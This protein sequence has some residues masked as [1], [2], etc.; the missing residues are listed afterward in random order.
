MVST[1]CG[2]GCFP[3][4]SSVPSKE[5]RRTLTDQNKIFEETLEFISKVP[6]FKPIPPENHVPLAKA[7]STRWFIDGENIIKQGDSGSEFFVIRKGKAA[8]LVDGHVVAI[9]GKGDFFGELAMLHGTPRSATVAATEGDV[10]CLAI[11]REEFNELD[12]RK[13]LNF[14]KRKAIVMDESPQTCKW[15]PPKTEEEKEFIKKSFM[16]DFFIGSHFKDMTDEQ[17]QE[18]CKAAYIEK[19]ERDTNIITQGDTKADFFYILQSGTADV[20]KDGQKVLSY[21]PGGSFG[22][23]ALV[24]QAPRAATVRITS[25]SQVW[26]IPRSAMRKALQQHVKAKVAGYKKILD[27]V[28]LFDSMSDQDKELLADALLE[29]TY[30]QGQ[31]VTKQ[32]EEP[33]AFF[34]LEAGAVSVVENGVETACLNANGLICE[35]LPH[36]GQREVMEDMPYYCT[37]TV[38][39]PKAT[40]LVLRREILARVMKRN[41]EQESVHK[42]MVEYNLEELST[43]GLL[44]CGGF[45]KVTLETY[46][47][48][49]QVF[50]LKKISKGFLVQ[51]D[52]TTQIMNEKRILRMCHSPFLVQSAATFNSA[53]YLY[54]LLEPALGGELYHVY[55]VHDLHGREDLARFYS[56]CVIKGLE[57]LHERCII[58]RDMKP[59]N[60]L[61]DNKGYCKI[62][63]FGLAKFCVGKTFTTCGTPEYFAP[64]MIKSVGHTTSLDWWTVGILIYELMMGG[65]PFTAKDTA[66]IIGKIMKG[67]DKCPLP[68]TRSWADLVKKLCK[69][70]PCE[71]LPVKP[72]GVKNL[73]GHA[74]Y[75][76]AGF[77]FAALAT[78]RMTAPWIP[79]EADEDAANFD[80]DEE[81]APPEVPYTDAGDGWD[82]DFEDKWGPQ[83]FDLSHTHKEKECPLETDK[84]LKSAMAKIQAENCMKAFMMQQRKKKEEQ[85]KQQEQA[86]QEAKAKQGQTDEEA[87]NWGTAVAGA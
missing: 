51:K 34:V 29:T 75:H 52:Q 58:Y 56:A 81:D 16:S 82:E 20:F 64:E 80:A 36:F 13:K 37:R 59:E 47:P 28:H 73:A 54:F 60:L 33:K 57:H 9:L 83:T 76:D 65:P 18:I 84:K 79:E 70:S 35:H 26:C 62:T 10:Q 5:L 69:F 50:A 85:A 4:K 32:G 68:M 12:L 41:E 55:A 45:G 42:D 19:V 53:Q 2:G 22:G 46:E 61:L 27:K 43:K 48:T 78:G 3:S 44:G 40:F 8:V 24:F 63:D 74:W 6:V 7:F 49:Q 31:L 25:D 14:K 71:R 72:G 30:T 17:L 67:L 86:Q 15:I 77:E 66:G 87:T 11:T 39:T 38:L 1:L 23:L 21:K